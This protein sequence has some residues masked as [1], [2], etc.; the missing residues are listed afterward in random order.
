MPIAAGY[1]HNSSGAAMAFAIMHDSI[2]GFWSCDQNGAWAT[3]SA[4][5][6]LQVTASAYGYDAETLTCT[7][8]NVKHDPDFN[9]DVYWLVFTLK[10]STTTTTTNGNGW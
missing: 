10:K 2:D 1:V 6:G 3:F 4:Y 8:D 7:P 5:S 9:T